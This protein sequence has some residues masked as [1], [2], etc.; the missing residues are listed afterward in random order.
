MTANDLEQSFNS[1]TTAET[2]A[3]WWQT[4]VAINMIWH[5]LHFLRYWLWKKIILAEVTFQGYSGSW[6]VTVFGLFAEVQLATIVN[7]PSNLSRNL[8]S[9][10]G[11][12][13]SWTWLDRDVKTNLCLCIPPQTA[14]LFPST[15]A[16]PPTPIGSSVNVANCATIRSS[17]TNVYT[18][19]QN[20]I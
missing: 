11:M 18:A 20:I 9:M 14:K 1:N 17:A 16:K 10:D 7:Q 3:H 8:V 2:E 6:A 19:I 15:A 12:T 5:I 4:L 13:R